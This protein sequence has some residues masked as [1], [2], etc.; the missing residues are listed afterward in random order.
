MC[1]GGKQEDIRRISLEHEPEVDSWISQARSLREDIHLAEQQADEI[2]K[3][4]EE[5]KVR[6]FPVRLRSTDPPRLMRTER[7]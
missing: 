7:P 3:L 2:V 5:E 4:A 1:G 6:R